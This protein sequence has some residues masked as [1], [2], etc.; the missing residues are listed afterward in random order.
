MVP[1]AR[2]Q[3]PTL[4]GDAFVFIDGQPMI[5]LPLFRASNASR[6]D[7]RRP[8]RWRSGLR[9]GPRYTSSSDTASDVGCSGSVAPSLPVPL[10]RTAPAIV[11][12]MG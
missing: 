2:G 5:A 11:N 4:T 12:G 8:S 10:R 1:P 3:D 6:T 9:C 7:G